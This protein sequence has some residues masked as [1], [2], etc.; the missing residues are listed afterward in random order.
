MHP[1]LEVAFCVPQQKYGPLPMLKG[2]EQGVLALQEDCAETAE[3]EFAA[4]R[5]TKRRLAIGAIIT[6]CISRRKTNQNEARRPV[7]PS[8]LEGG[9]LEEPALRPELLPPP[10]AAP[11]S[12]LQTID[13][14]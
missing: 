4:I 10:Q 2:P 14:K 3:K 8:V 5:R 9:V 6:F 1:E 11:S 12:L 13:Q 7:S